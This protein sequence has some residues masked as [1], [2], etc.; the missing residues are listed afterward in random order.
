MLK[1][2]IV[3]DAQYDFMSKDDGALYVPGA[4]D[5]V[6]TMDQY[7]E[8]ITIENGYLGVIFTADSH[9]AE[10]YPDSEEAKEFPPHCYMG[11]DGF[12]F[13]V[14]PS[15]VVPPSEGGVDRYILNK[16]VFNMWEESS[17]KL[18]PFKVTGEPV[19]IGGEQD[20]EQ[21]F[22]SMADAGVEDIEV[23]GV[24]SDY[25]VKWAI[26]GLL[27]RKFNVVVYDNLVAGIQRD[28]HQV[29]KED[30]PTEL[31]SGQLQVL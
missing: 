18:R 17:L 12:N 2:A 27:I 8:S 31:A 3:V 21:F 15:K 20:R 7:L 1:I 6:E 9:D 14:D 30:F 23:I 13:S 5:I 10:T 4:E 16:G 19:S 28:I 11:T 29:A 25:C 22:K 26:E 24:A